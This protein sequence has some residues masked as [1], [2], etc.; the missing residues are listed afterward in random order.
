MSVNYP[1]LFSPIDLGC[2]ILPN[3][4]LM[5]SMHTGLEESENGFQKMAAFYAERVRGGV[6]LIVTGGIAPNTAGRLTPH[7]AQLTEQRQVSEH[8][9]VTD[10]VHH[11]GGRIAMQILHGGRYSQH[12][13]LVA[14]SAIQSPIIPFMPREL[15]HSDILQTIS[16]YVS[17]AKLAQQAGYDGVEVMGSEG[18]LINQFLVSSTN[19]RSD[20]WGGPIENRMRFAVEIVARIR[21]AVGKNF[22][23]IYRLS[24][25]DLV[26]GGQKWEEVV[27]LA[28]AI[29]NAGASIINTGIGWHEARVPTIA[30][31][32]PR[33]AFTWVTRKLKG[34]I[35]IPLVASNRINTPNVAEDVLARD[36][37]DMVSMA[38][39]LLADADFLQKARQGKSDEINTCIACNQAC[40]DHA[41]FGKRAT[42][43]VNP[44]ACY[45]TELN[46]ATV[47]SA[48]KIAVVGGGAAGMS[49][50]AHAAE[51]GHDV[52]LFEAAS[53]LGGQLNIAKQV[54]GKEEFHETLRYF[55]RRIEL[56]GVKVHLGQRVG[57]EQL[58]A[59][60]F[61][62]VVLATGVMPRVPDISGI[63]HPKVLSYPDVLLRRVSVGKKVVI[64]GAG[65]IGFDMAEFLVA[66]EGHRPDIPHFLAEWGIDSQ[67]KERGALSAVQAP[68]RPARNVTMCQRKSDKMGAGLGKSTGWI[69]R[70]SMK[71]NDVEMLTGVSYERIDDQGVWI[72]EGEHSALRC[73]NADNVINCT[74]Q[75][76]QRDLLAPL[77]AQGVVVHVI[78][79]ADV[80]AELD[81]KRAIRQGAELAA[82][83]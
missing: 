57:A 39:P 44:R 74:G 4:V 76:S 11:A 78:G 65:G 48:K 10:V 7:A 45:E 69:H 26:P 79:G 70:A 32:V 12:P 51:R 20:A 53:E 34:E 31:M 66:K 46:F 19:R 41:Y 36:D 61:D 25:L 18:Y 16:D 63:D 27:Q 35:S 82:L 1:R 30:T 37:A 17:C 13:A 47:A 38:R 58:I 60:G 28:K 21:E 83:V 15:S 62:E 64:L 77:H 24:M 72:R 2:C 49:F 33:G 14:P 9:I 80:A 81:A 23:I 59:G 43:L 67:Y 50:S 68:L 3:R 54:P 6:G 56:A 5:G 42:C 29:E 71:M 40:L 8:R 73:I 55:R 75:L 22:I 52:F